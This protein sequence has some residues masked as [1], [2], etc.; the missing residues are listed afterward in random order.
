MTKNSTGPDP[1]EITETPRITLCATPKCTKALDLNDAH[2]LDRNAEARH[3]DA[4]E[5]RRR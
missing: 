3:L 5:C 1:R 2:R 4:K